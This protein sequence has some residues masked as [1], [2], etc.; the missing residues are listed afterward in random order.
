VQDENIG[1]GYNSDTSF[2][3][4]L[5]SQVIALEAERPAKQDIELHYDS[6]GPLSVSLQLCDSPHLHRG[7]P[8]YFHIAR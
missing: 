4:T 8:G 6:Y 3:A 5:N 2:V 7:P 1:L